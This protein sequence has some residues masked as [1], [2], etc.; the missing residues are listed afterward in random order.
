MKI[1][2]TKKFR[3]LRSE[4]YSYNFNKINGYFERWG[5]TQ[6]DDPDYCPF[7]CEIADIEIVVDGCPKGNSGKI[8]NFCYKGNGIGAPQYMSLETFKVVFS[9]LPKI[10]TQI[11]FGITSVNANPDT[12]SIMKYC[13]DN[14]VIPNVTISGRDNL[15][16]AQIKELVSLLGAAAFSI[17]QEDKDQCYDLIER[18]A[19]AGLKQQ[20]VHFMIS[21]ETLPFAYEVIKDIQNDKRLSNINAIVWLSLK[22]K[23]R[24]VIY[25][26]LPQ[27]KFT[28]LVQHCLK[29]NI[30]FGMDSCGAHKTLKSLTDEQRKQFGNCIE[31][32]ESTRMSLYCDYLGRFFPCSFVAG[33]KLDIWE[34]GINLLEVTDFLKDVWFHPSTVAFR[35]KV[36]EC[37]KNC[38]NCCHFQV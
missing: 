31:D 17:Y 10:L 21:L 4:N 6:E 20:N 11:A 18:F 9:K 36:V 30:R 33:E 8:C 35:D 26:Q 28:E 32:C 15:T 29:N 7:G 13:R 37:N 27:D 5:K 3:K 25:H 2:N 1:I 23:G 14:G 34:N 12:I 16:D 38:D 24:G 19:K 22:P